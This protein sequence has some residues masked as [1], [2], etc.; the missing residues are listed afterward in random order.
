MDVYESMAALDRESGESDASA[1]MFALMAAQVR[2]GIGPVLFQEIETIPEKIP[3][4]DGILLDATLFIPDAS[5]SWPVILV[6]NPYP[7]IKLMYDVM[8]MPDLAKCGY[9]VL[10]VSVRG[11]MASEGEWLPFVNEKKD[12]LAVLDWIGEQSWCNGN[13]GMFGGSYLGHTQLCLAGKTHPLLKTMFVQVWGSTKYEGF[14]RRGMYREDVFTMWPAQM[15]GDNRHA[16]RTADEEAALEDKALTVY[17]RI[18]LGQALIG[19]DVPWLEEWMH[20]PE[21]TDSCWQTGFWDEMHRDIESMDIPIYLCGGWYD[22]FIGGLM[23]TFRRMPAD[24]RKQSRMLIGPWQHDGSAGGTLEYPD[25]GIY[26]MGQI[27]AAREWFDYMLKGEPFP[28]GL[29]V[30][31]TYSVGEN[32]WRTWSPAF[33]TT[34]ETVKTFYMT[35][36]QTLSDV[37]S[38]AQRDISYVY[39]PKNPVRSRGGMMIINHNDRYASAECSIE[40]E[41]VGARDDVISFVSEPLNENLLIAGSIKAVIVVSSDAPATAFTVKVCEIFADGRSFNIRDD[42]TDIRW[43]EDGTFGTY[44]PGTPV[45]LTFDM[46]PIVW[47]LSKGSRLRVDISS[48]NYPAYAVHANETGPWADLIPTRTAVQTLHIGADAARIELPT[49]NLI[50]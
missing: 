22:I 15:M 16:M 2:E 14:Y 42:I 13:V 45:E 7:S 47:Q 29:G 18:N 34:K 8:Y 4:P 50:I 26:G 32:K 43:Q 46:I 17:P 9:A 5:Q 23:D 35:P 19:E 37:P 41:E 20:S 21:L 6:T 10:L 28:H 39:D 30:I 3:M 31:E 11:T 48:S 40:Q 24:I 49:S 44:E 12:G 33:L 25:E 38:D 27:R 36:E 1:D